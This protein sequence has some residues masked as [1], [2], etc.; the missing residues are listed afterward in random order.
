MKRPGPRNSDLCRSGFEILRN[1]CVSLTSVQ[2]GNVSRGKKAVPS[3]KSK[4]LAKSVTLH[5]EP[6]KAVKSAFDGFDPEVRKRALAI[7]GLIGEVASKTDCGGLE[8]TL[9]WGFPS[10]L[11][12][13]GRG[14]TIRLEPGPSNEG[15]AM[16][17]HC[18]SRMM[19][20]FV[21]RPSVGVKPDGSRGI[22]IPLKG[23]LPLTELRRFIGLALTYHDWKSGSAD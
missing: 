6:L 3:A 9:K 5:S 13:S 12:G 22:L 10:Y 23:K 11:A 19:E 7:R 2:N 4:G 1:D 18:Q 20:R 14:T 16:R 8:E 15:V 17:V 21:D